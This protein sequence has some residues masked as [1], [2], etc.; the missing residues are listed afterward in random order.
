MPY[1]NNSVKALQTLKIGNNRL[2]TNKDFI[3]GLGKTS[4][5]RKRIHLLHQAT[6]DQ[7]LALIESAWNILRNRN[8]VLKQKQI[9]RLRTSANQI[10]ALSRARTAKTARRILLKS[11]AAAAASATTNNQIGQGLP[12][13]TAVLPIA[14]LLANIL[15]PL[16]T[17]KQ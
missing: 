5:S 7:L 14:S 15:L 6:S 8:F 11:E 10:R 12:I 13:A 1:N 4:S 9:E 16:L 2:S 17:S 3:V